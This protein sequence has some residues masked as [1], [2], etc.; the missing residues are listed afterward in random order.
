MI[1]DNTEGRIVLHLKDL[2]KQ[3]FARILLIKPSAVGDVIHAL[4][5]LAKLRKRYPAARIDWMLTPENAQ[6]VG[7]HPAISNV[8]LFERRA[9]GRPWRDWSSSLDFVRMISNLREANYD[10][11]IDLH[12]QFRSAFFTLATGAQTRIGFDRPRR[13]VRHAGRALPEEAFHH[14]WQGARELSWIAYTHR[15][16]IPTLDAH[17]ID[18]YLWLGELLDLPTGPPETNL[19]IA[20]EARE[21]VDQLLKSEGVGEKPIALLSPGTIWETKRWLSENFAAVGRHFAE[22]DWAVILTGAGKDVRA[23]QEVA[24]Q[25]PQAINLCA[26]TNLSDLAALTQRASICI[27]NDSGPMH[28]AAALGTPLVAIFGPTDPLWVGPYGRA[29]SVVRAG[30]PCSPC[31]LRHLRQCRHNHACM[32]EVTAEMVIERAEETLRRTPCG[33]GFQPV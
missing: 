22:M 15:I 2:R 10:L 3:G 20:P 5:V 16:G 18:R 13:R 11:V 19:P 30:V 1:S 21:R 4:P 26:R 23:C 29:D 14:A 7:R 8:V 9:Y 32:H 33:T 6:L 28:L 17:A 24:A 12:G 31:Y 25:C 27:T